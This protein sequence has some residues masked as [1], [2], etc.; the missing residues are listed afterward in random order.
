VAHDLALLPQAVVATH[1]ETMHLIEGHRLFGRGIGYVDAH[2]I[3][4]TRILDDALLW[5][6]DGR[7]EAVAV[8]M[9]VVYRP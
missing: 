2:L 4:A 6:F 3:A 8:Q 9:K 1:W 7:L 5:T